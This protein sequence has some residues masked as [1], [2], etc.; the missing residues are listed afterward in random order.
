M[1]VSSFFRL[2]I[3]TPPPPPVRGAFSLSSSV[4]AQIGASCDGDRG[5]D[6]D[7]KAALSDDTEPRG[8]VYDASPLSSITSS[9]R[10][11]TFR[12]RALRALFGVL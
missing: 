8:G 3:V 2:S 6:D 4:D 5:G 1:L 7:S 9:L 10:V 12:A 11:D